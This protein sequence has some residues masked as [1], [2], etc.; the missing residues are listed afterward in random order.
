MEGIL[1]PLEI[2]GLALGEFLLRL[3]NQAPVLGREG[4]N[5]LADAGDRL[6]DG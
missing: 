1:L 4:E 5:V 6:V 2:V 3:A